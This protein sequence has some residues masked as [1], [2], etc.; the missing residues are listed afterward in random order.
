MNA[1]TL[2]VKSS[3]L[4]NEKFRKGTYFSS[5]SITSNSSL[6]I[7]LS[8]ISRH[9]RIGN[10]SICDK[11]PLCLRHDIYQQA[12]NLLSIPESLWNICQCGIYEDQIR[13]CQFEH[14]IG[15][16][17]VIDDGHHKGGKF[18]E[19]VFN[20]NGLKF[21]IVVL[22]YGTESTRRKTMPRGDLQ[23]VGVPSFF[24]KG[25][26]QRKGNYYLKWQL[27]PEYKKHKVEIIST[28]YNKYSGWVD[29]HSVHGLMNE[30]KNI[31]KQFICIHNN[32]HINGKYG[33][34][35]LCIKRM[36]VCIYRT[37]NA[38]PIDSLVINGKCFKKPNIINYNISTNINGCYDSVVSSNNNN[39]IF[40]G[41]KQYLPGSA[42]G[43]VVHNAAGINNNMYKSKFGASVSQHKINSS[44]IYNGNEHNTITEKTT[45]LMGHNIQN[46]GKLNDNLTR[47]NVQLYINNDELRAKLK[48]KDE[49][50][51]GLREEL[52]LKNTT[53][54]GYYNV[55]MQILNAQSESNIAFTGYYNNKDGIPLTDSNSAIH[56]SEIPSYTQQHHYH[57]DDAASKKISYENNTSNLIPSSIVTDDMLT[58]LLETNNGIQLLNNTNIPIPNNI[59]EMTNNNS[60]QQ[61]TEYSRYND[62]NIVSCDD[63]QVVTNYTLNSKSNNNVINTST[64]INNSVCDYGAN[65]IESN[66]TPILTN[67]GLNS[68]SN[69]TDIIPTE[70]DYQHEQFGWHWIEKRV[71]IEWEKDVIWNAVI[72]DYNKVNK[73]VLLYFKT[74]NSHKW[75]DKSELWGH[76]IVDIEPIK[77][78]YPYKVPTSIKFKSLKLDY[79]APLEVK[80]RDGRRYEAFVDG[81]CRKSKRYHVQYETGSEWRWPI[82]EEMNTIKQFKT[83][84]MEQKRINAIKC[85][86]V[87]SPV[88]WDPELWGLEESWYDDSYVPASN[89]IPM[90]NRYHV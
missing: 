72:M 63:I 79:Y 54:N 64:T 19:L 85:K 62:I 77:T 8:N 90:I 58:K 24:D 73:R 1:P 26:I 53:L 61:D 30:N 40:N 45:V 82:Q 44:D 14:I 69:D 46:L 78:Y 51:H 47:E 81:Y 66:K 74:Q 16:D 4:Q 27:K 38:A 43:D 41:A 33:S 65:N 88:Q 7:A 71:Q 23:K 50:V 9:N 57:I 10:Y 11:R 42:N 25:F 20:I 67:S 87:V 59:M 37:N 83:K 34:V 70:L 32:P 39:I 6:Y 3:N 49:L 15:L 60:Y 89:V 55:V 17:R 5:I 31:I 35:D 76:V 13:T 29:C 12:G 28:L 84:E 56:S 52:K 2:S 86:I 21:H 80:Y 75:F 22:S 18:N 48:A 68:K 36:E